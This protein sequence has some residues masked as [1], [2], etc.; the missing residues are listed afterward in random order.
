MTNQCTDII[1]IEQSPR[2]LLYVVPS[3]IKF[4]EV[5][6]L[7][8]CMEERKPMPMNDALRDLFYRGRHYSLY[9]IPDSI[10]APIDYCYVIYPNSD[11]M[12]ENR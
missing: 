10:R 11:H 4:Q 2:T 5:V 9:C 1:P 7:D 3:V 8:D 6:I 12:E